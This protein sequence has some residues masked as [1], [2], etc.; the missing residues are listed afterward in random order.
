MEWMIQ[1]QNRMRNG[2]L[3][4]VSYYGVDDETDYRELQFHI[5]LISINILW[6]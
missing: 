1:I 3:V 4:G 5:G 2:F 6:V